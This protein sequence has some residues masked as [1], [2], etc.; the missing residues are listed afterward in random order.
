[1]NRIIL[2]GNG[3]D[4]AHDLPT[5]YENFIEWYWRDWGHR[6]ANSN[7][8]EEEDIL[9]S[10]RLH[11]SVCSSGWRNVPAYYWKEN[12][13]ESEFI[14]RVKKDKHLCDFHVKSVFFQEIIKKIE[15]KGWVDIEQEYYRL[16][17]IVYIDQPKHINDELCHIKS[18][19]IEYLK[20][21]QETSTIKIKPEIRSQILGPLHKKEI[22]IE[23]Q[24]V[25]YDMIEE[26]LD[27][28]DDDWN[29]LLESYNIDNLNPQ[30][31]V[32]LINRVKHN[33]IADK[34]NRGIK[35]IDSED[36]HHAFFFPDR[37]MILDFNYTNTAGL[38]LPHANRFSINHIHGN[39]SEPS[40]IIFGYGDE[41]DDEF[42]NLMKKN[43]N[44][45]LRYIKSFR[46]LETLNYR[47]ML[48]FIESAPY[49]L[50]IMG[51][52]CGT[53]DRTLLSTLF[54]HKNCV[55]IK[56][57]Y[58]CKDDGTDNYIDLIQNISRSF[59]NPRIMRDRVVSK[60]FCEELGRKNKK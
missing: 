17:N 2:I 41:L 18:K 4:L 22:A 42:R 27:Y 21:V 48:S 39:F 51:H 3:F 28:L 60:G 15:E 54:E 26:R 32:D 16:L 8:L 11:R 30:Y 31:S 35:Q 38:Y 19:L 7:N 10:F 24:Q 43:V 9:C 13:S 37:I 5:R 25:W 36:Y 44:E 20:K 53:S 45:Y 59:S 12:V 47:R 29:E 55:S 33:I 6:L 23:S 57:Y 14:D 58:Y 49:Q 56:P 50:C 52:S 40:N 1:M 46:Y 34:E